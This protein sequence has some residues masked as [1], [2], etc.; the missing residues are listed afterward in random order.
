MT[1]RTAMSTG[2]GQ[3]GRQKF[4]MLVQKDGSLRPDAES[5]VASRKSQILRRFRGK[6]RRLSSINGAV[7]PADLD[8]SST[9]FF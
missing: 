2:V 3:N 4:Y 7:K 6:R 5:V 9:Q 8:V 1:A